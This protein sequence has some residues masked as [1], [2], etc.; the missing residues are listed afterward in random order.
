MMK[1]LLVIALMLVGLGLVISPAMAFTP[2]VK[3][4]LVAI[5][6]ADK[7]VS[8]EAVVMADYWQ[9]YKMPL[10]PA[11]ANWDPDHWHLIISADQVTPE[12][13]RVPMFAGWATDVEISKDL[14][15]L[16]A[17]ADYYDVRTFTDRMNKNSPYPDMKAKGTP[18]SVYFTWTTKD[19]KEK[20]VT[21][22]DFLE[23]STGKK[24][25]FVYLGKQHPSHCIVCLYSCVG[26]RVSNAALTVRDYM[27]RGAVWTLK[28]GV[29]PPDGTTVLV[30]IKL[31]K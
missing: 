25:Q 18:M 13:P 30:T 19:G 21:P 12:I 22:D 23:N 20:T 29:L 1:K 9:K 10:N 11:N 6:K 3:P 17:K 28:K 24:L 4:T 31:K 14:A 16:G 2:T 5:D 8:F 15:S 27:D 26:G 7:S